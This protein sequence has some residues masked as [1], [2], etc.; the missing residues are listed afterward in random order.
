MGLMTLDFEPG[1]DVAIKRDQKQKSRIS[2]ILT[3]NHDFMPLYELVYCSLKNN[4]LK[5]LH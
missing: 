2:T 4:K 1:C 3:Q 5:T